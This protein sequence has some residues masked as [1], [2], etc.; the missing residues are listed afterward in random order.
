MPHSPTNSRSSAGSPVRVQDALMATFDSWLGAFTLEQLRPFGQVPETEEFSRRNSLEMRALV[1]LKREAVS[2]PV[3]NK[4]MLAHT[5]VVL[6]AFEP[7][8]DIGGVNFV[9]SIPERWWN[10]RRLSP[11]DVRSALRGEVEA[12]L[13]GRDQEEVFPRKYADELRT[14]LEEC[15]RT[16][17]ATTFDFRPAFVTADQ[18]GKTSGTLEDHGEWQ[19]AYKIRDDSSV[20]IS[21]RRVDVATDLL[22]PVEVLKQSPGAVQDW[23]LLEV[24]L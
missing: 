6:M 7:P 1:H 4:G 16:M 24:C 22:V 20:R 10:E 12:R 3:N 13:Q 11:E 19:I 17:P 9:I 5:E 18:M 23:V 14:D 21:L 8:Q 2:F 15:I